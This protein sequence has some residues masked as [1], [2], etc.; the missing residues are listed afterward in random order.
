MKKKYK[1]KIK[2]KNK[3]KKIRRKKIQVKP[4]FVRQF[5][6]TERSLVIG[7]SR[8][9]VEILRFQTCAELQFI[10]SNK[11]IVAFLGS[12][13]VKISC[14]AL[15]GKDRR[16]FV[17]INEFFDYQ[18]QITRTR[19]VEGQSVEDLIPNDITLNLFFKKINSRLALL[20]F[21]IELF[22]YLETRKVA[23]RGR[24]PTSHITPQWKTRN[25]CGN[26]KQCSSKHCKKRLAPMNIEYFIVMK[27]ARIW[28]T[29]SL[30][31]HVKILCGAS[32]TLDWI[33]RILMGEALRSRNIGH[34]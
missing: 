8:Q 29:Q 20:S 32:A 33:V 15:F 12:I 21:A 17:D 16:L 13:T 24:E 18:N 3:E 26:F 14:I 23:T 2:E 7:S 5:Y 1:R 22:S 34:C 31:I 11:Q 25:D 19:K 28:I 4:T 6:L 30:T 9:R 10:G 27:I